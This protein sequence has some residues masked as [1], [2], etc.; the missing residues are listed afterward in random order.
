M[1]NGEGESH[2]HDCDGDYGCGNDG[3]GDFKLE[4]GSVVDLIFAIYM[5]L[6]HMQL[7]SPFLAEIDFEVRQVSD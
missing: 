6:F 5:F 1:V 4:Q 3:D 7:I 2:D